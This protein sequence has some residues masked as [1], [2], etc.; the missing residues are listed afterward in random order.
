MRDFVPSPASATA[1]RRPDAEPTLGG[2]RRNGNLRRRGLRRHY[3]QSIDAAGRFATIG[4]A[5]VLDRP[6]AFAIV[7]VPR[8]VYGTP[9]VP[10]YLP[11]LH[12]LHHRE[13][14][15]MSQHRY[16]TGQIVESR[17]DGLGVI[18]PGRYEIVRQLPATV[19][20]TN[21]YR[22]K[23]VLTGQER[24]LTENDLDGPG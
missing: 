8:S 23:S 12:T 18:P 14:L 7:T 21:Q 1:P 5:G 3:R 22:V 6:L 2:Q 15:T 9:S 20:G 11:R 4:G 24:V 19:A 17:A 16:R 13:T 10:G